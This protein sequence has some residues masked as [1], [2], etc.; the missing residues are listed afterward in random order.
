MIDLRIKITVVIE[1]KY[2]ELA[3]R[4]LPRRS[5]STLPDLTACT[6]SYHRGLEGW[7]VAEGRSTPLLRAYGLKLVSRVRIPH[8]PPTKELSH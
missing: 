6:E 3:V 8:S 7:R 4:V 2:L 1:E 5:A